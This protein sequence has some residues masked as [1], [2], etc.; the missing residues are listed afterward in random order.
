[1]EYFRTKLDLAQWKEEIEILQCEIERT[2][3][4]FSL[5]SHTWNC[6]AREATSPGYAEYAYQAADIYARRALQ[7]K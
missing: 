6:I 4:W 1:V 7:C 2:F 5:L 3:T